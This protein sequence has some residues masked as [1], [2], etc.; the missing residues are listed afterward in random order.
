MISPKISIAAIFT[1]VCR[2]FSLVSCRS[3]CVD[4]MERC[5]NRQPRV[6]RLVSAW[7]P[8]VRGDVEPDDESDDPLIGVA[9]G[10]SGHYW[11]LNSGVFVDIARESWC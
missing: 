1:S 7:N 10:D 8:N 3:C 5:G 2:D 4:A 11:C 6:E 9:K